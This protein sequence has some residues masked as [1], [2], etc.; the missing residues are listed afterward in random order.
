MLNLS[1]TPRTPAQLLAVPV[2]ESARWVSNARDSR[3]QPIQHGELAYAL[4]EEAEGLGLQV[5][6]HRWMAT[7]PD[8]TELYGCIDFHHSASLEVPEDIVFSIGV[9]HSNAGRYALNLVTGG[10]V[11]VCTNGLL[12]G[13]RVLSRRHTD[14]LDLRETVRGGIRAA[15]DDMGELGTWVRRLK[16][17]PLTDEQADLVMMAGARSRALSWSALRH[18]DH[19]WRRPPHLDFEPR[20]AWSLYNAFTEVARERPPEVQLKA[21]RGLR[22]LFDE[23]ELEPLLVPHQRHAYA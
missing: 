9:R 11:I 3:W 15:I 14:D 2:P 12:M 4:L 18:V 22:T 16:M 10:H 6:Q 7:G 20:T 1:K 13:E 21:L 5:A 17:T 19:A 8:L 23:R